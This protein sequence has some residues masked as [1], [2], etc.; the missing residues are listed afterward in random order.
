M[1]KTLATKNLPKLDT[2]HGRFPFSW[3]RYINLYFDSLFFLFLLLLMNHMSE[4][5]QP[6]EKFQTQ[7]F[8]TSFEEDWDE[9]SCSE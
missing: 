9:K 5:S 4:K 6:L 7:K 8:E 2:M 1:D 3:L